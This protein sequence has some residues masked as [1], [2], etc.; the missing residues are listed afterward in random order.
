MSIQLVSRAKAAGVRLSPRDVFERKTVAGLAEVAALGDG[1][2][3]GVLDELPGGGV[4]EV[5]L[6]PIMRWMLDRGGAGFGRF[7]QAV[8]LICRRN[9]RVP[10]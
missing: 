2:R 9:R 3:R 5:P 10:G 6:T 8:I 7:S 4:G 1:D